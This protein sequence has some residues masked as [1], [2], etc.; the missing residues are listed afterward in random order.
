[1]ETFPE[2]ICK[3]NSLQLDLEG[4]V[5]AIQHI[6]RNLFAISV[7]DNPRT[8]IYRYHKVDV[9]LEGL[10]V[11]VRVPENPT[12]GH[13]KAHAVII[14]VD[15]RAKETINIEEAAKKTVD[16]EEAVKETINIEEA[17]KE[18]L[19]IDETKKET[20]DIKEAAKETIDIEVPTKEKTEIE[21]ALGRHRQI[22]TNTIVLIINN[23]STKSLL[24]A[25]DVIQDEYKAFPRAH[26]IKNLQSRINNNLDC[27][28]HFVELFETNDENLQATFDSL[29]NMALVL[30]SDS[31]LM[32]LDVN[33][34][35][36]FQEYNHHWLYLSQKN[37]VHLLAQRNLGKSINMLAGD[38]SEE[39]MFKLLSD[40]DIHHNTPLVTAALRGS[41]VAL[42]AML[43]FYSSTIN[44]S[45]IHR[46][47]NSVKKEIINQMLHS[48][49]TLNHSLTYHIIQTSK[50]FL[51][52][53]G[54]ILQMEK[55]FH[56][57]SKDITTENEQEEE[58]DEFLQLNICLQ[59]KQGSTAETSLAMKL[60][61]STRE[62][63]MGAM[64]ATIFIFVFLVAIFDLCLQIVDVVTDGLLGEKYY[65]DWVQGNH[66]NVQ[67][68]IIPPE[69]V[70]LQ[71]YPTQLHAKFK[72]MYYAMF[73][74]APCIFYIVDILRSL[75]CGTACM[76][77]SEQKKTKLNLITDW[78]VVI[79]FPIS[80]FLWP[81]IIN[82]QKSYCLFK[83]HTTKGY[84][85]LKWKAAAKEMAAKVGM[86]HLTEVCIES[87][88]ISILNWY[89]ILPTILLEVD[90]SV[91]SADNRISLST[92]SFLTSIV[93]LAWSFTS[94]VAEQKDGALALTW[95]PVSR[96]VLFVSN[97]LLIFARLNCLVLFAFYFGPGN[98]H[99][100]MLFLL[101]HIIFMMAIHAYNVLRYMSVETNQN[102]TNTICFIGRLFY[103]SLL[104]GL[105]NVFIN[106][107]VNVSL[108]NQKTLGKKKKKSFYRQTVGDLIFLLENIIC[109]VFG[110]LTDVD[111]INN[112][113]TMT[114]FVSIVF[115][116][117]IVGLLLKIFYYKILHLWADL[118]PTFDYKKKSFTRA[119]ESIHFYKKTK[120]SM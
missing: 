90:S 28:R 93:S 59:E 1:M 69:N 16:T 68:D 94:Y 40:Q 38:I 26:E 73:M 54:T 8:G 2:E 91:Y 87:T 34:K 19:D 119:D 35:A 79:F 85:Q 46:P 112:P 74:V 76:K 81:V 102:E 70:T 106:N 6:L 33:K 84:E 18:R 62:A 107:F 109:V 103:V 52:P 11:N 12:N 47:E 64:C 82:I 4:D 100:V 67:E 27:E 57:I 23:I 14:A 39:D 56:V 44:M 50:K 105:A 120:T 10:E 95:D 22:G 31:H 3:V 9:D 115:T 80:V 72:F 114:Y 41:G 101:C 15:L 32:S 30:S 36:L 13:P 118:T 58:M 116:C 86:V 75:K 61:K 104:N 88:F 24:K 92:V 113:I 60:F 98:I 117:H 21:E 89:D 49:D 5:T 43:N 65:Q 17:A 96:L 37:I 55:D 29:I 83:Y 110:C 7:N 51:G 25:N 48:S 53:Y 99:Q 78:L 77:G 63:S 111:P 66:T 45:D 97:L 20:I 71:F 42:A 108:N